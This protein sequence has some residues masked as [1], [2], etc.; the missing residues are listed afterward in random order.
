MSSKQ[1]SIKSFFGKS[2]K[3]KGVK[4]QKEKDL[5]DAQ[6]TN[7]GAPLSDRKSLCSENFI[8]PL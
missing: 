1:M 5:R 2:K 3:R 7:M 4:S 8:K 6:I